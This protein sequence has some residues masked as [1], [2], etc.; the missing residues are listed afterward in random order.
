M[1]ERKNI[2]QNTN[3][4]IKNELSNALNAFYLEKEDSIKFKLSSIN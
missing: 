2:I 3:K 1:N 4:K